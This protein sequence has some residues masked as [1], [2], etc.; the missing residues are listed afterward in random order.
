VKVSAAVALLVATAVLT[1]TSTLV[2]SDPPGLEAV[3]VVP[4][5][6]QVTPVAASVPKVTVLLPSA[7]TRLVPVTVTRVPPALTP[8]VGEILVTTGAPGVTTVDWV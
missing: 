2:P 5:A 3:Q 8:D 6:L 1:W 7:L 4:S